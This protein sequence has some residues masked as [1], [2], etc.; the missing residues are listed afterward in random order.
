MAKSERKTFARLLH[1][2]PP[3]LSPKSDDDDGLI[4]KRD[5]RHRRQ[6]RESNVICRLRV[7]I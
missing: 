4:L 7:L 6:P 2:P 1:M 3:P 5:P